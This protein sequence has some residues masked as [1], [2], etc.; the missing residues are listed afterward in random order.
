ME[1]IF[2]NDFLLIPPVIH[3]TVGE[4]MNLYFANLFAVLNP[5]DYAFQFDCE[6]GACCAERWHFTPG[7]EDVGSYE[8]SL[9]IYDDNGIAASG[10]CTIVIHDPEASS[11]KKLRLLMIGDSLTDQS[12]YPT[13]IHTLCKR[14]GIQLEML[15]T[16]VPEELYKQPGQVIQYP[17]PEL[18]P[19]VRHEGY[20][21]WTAGSFLTRKKADEVEVYHHWN[22]ASPFF[23]GDGDFDFAGYIEKYCGGKAPDVILI[24]LITNDLFGVNEGSYQE[25][26]GKY[27][28]NMSTLYDKLHHAAPESVI[29]I[30]L[31]PYCAQSQD[32]FGKKYGSKYFRRGM[33]KYC[34]MAFRELEKRFREQHREAPFIALYPAIDPVYGYPMEESE[35][36]AGSGIMVRRQIDGVHP[37]PAGYRQMAVAAFSSLLDL[38]EKR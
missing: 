38:L 21:G 4:E 2:M 34:P 22:C 27:V 26:T 10:K 24:G 5:A 13:H 23:N 30:V 28:E 8:A 1:Q 33:R 18:L 35:A 16:N 6:K 31:N 17:D 12:H 11:G 3:G 36:F 29:Y 37:A 14:Y 32:A 25:L 9:E 19:G 7:K 15:G 20:G